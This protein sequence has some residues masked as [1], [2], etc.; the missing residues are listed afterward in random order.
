LGLAGSTPNCASASVT[1]RRSIWPGCIGSSEGRE[2]D[3]MAIH[4][5]MPAQGCGIGAP[6]RP[7]PGSRSPGIHGEFDGTVRM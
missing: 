3:E 2:G 5:E 4:L 6:N 1:L 7:C